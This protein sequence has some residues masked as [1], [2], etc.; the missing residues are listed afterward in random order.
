[1][2]PRFITSW[3]CP[4]KRSNRLP[5]S[6]NKIPDDCGSL[7]LRHLHRRSLKLHRLVSRR[8]NSRMAGSANSN[9]KVKFSKRLLCTT[10]IVPFEEGI[11]FAGICVVS[12]TVHERNNI[13]AEN[14]AKMSLDLLTSSHTHEK[15][16]EIPPL[17][18]GLK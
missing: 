2:E 18:K 3:E 13:L 1:M 4:G 9:V 8:Q 12:C 10:P 11:R 14:A 16:N 5:L 7:K 15:K 6:T 17:S